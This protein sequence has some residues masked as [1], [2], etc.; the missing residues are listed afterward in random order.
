MEPVT[1]FLTGACLSRAGFNRKTALATVTMVLAAEAPDIDIAVYFAKGGIIGFAHHRGI[2]HTLIGIPF[3]CALVLAIV[4]LF[5]RWRA[6]VTKDVPAGCPAC[7]PGV[8]SGS[9]A[10]PRWGLLYGLALIAGYSHILLDYTNSYGVRPFEPFHNQWY[11]WDIVSIIEPTILAALIL[12]LVLPALFALINEEIGARSR[13]P[14]GR[15]GAIVALVVVL[16]IWGFRDFEHR[17]A[18]AA[19]DARLYHGAD[20]ERVSA[21]PYMI[22]PFKWMGVI[23]T[24]AF[25]E[26][27]TVDSTSGDVDPDG[28]AVTRYKPEETPVT[29]AAKKSYLGRVY[30][31]WAQYPMTETEPATVDGPRGPQPGYVVRFYDLRY[32]YPERTGTPLG[33]FVELDDQLNVLVM[34]TGRRGHPSR[35]PQP[36]TP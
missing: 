33:A 8:A 9:P 30:L 27:M 24:E 12:G 2:T 19:L 17:R 21:Y 3:V 20:P 34:D 36:R 28:R 14:R 25:F 18:V 15:A 10:N 16:F 5:H 13:G 11:S 35:S 31:D 7:P 29:L 6:R 23:E 32:M 22:N 1:H 4:Y 26:N